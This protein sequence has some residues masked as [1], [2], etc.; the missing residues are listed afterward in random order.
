[1]WGFYFTENSFVAQKTC[2]YLLFSYLRFTIWLFANC[3][4]KEKGDSE[5]S[6]SPLGLVVSR[7]FEPRQTVP[8]TVVLPLHH[9]TILNCLL[10]ESGAK[11]RHF[12]EPASVETIFF[13]PVLM[14]LGEEPCVCALFAPCDL[15]SYGSPV[16]FFR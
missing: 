9:E 10:F 2:I 14:I 11:I 13:I 15:L 12:S 4:L 5:N 16:S 7:G 3:C 1:M 6:E 8:K